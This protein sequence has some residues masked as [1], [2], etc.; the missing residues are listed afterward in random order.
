MQELLDIK[1]LLSPKKPW[2]HL[3]KCSER[4]VDNF[5][6]YLIS[7]AVAVVR[8]LRGKRCTTKSGLFDEFASALQFPY[9]FGE[10]W[11]AFDECLSDLE[12]LKGNAYIFL[13]S[14]ANEILS[15]ESDEELQ[16]FIDILKNIA[17]EWAISRENDKEQPRPAVPFHII[18]QY[19]PEV[20]ETFQLRLKQTKI[21]IDD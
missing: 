9:Y 10:N 15:K 7:Q 19:E 1:N 20:A 17:E 4:E 5:S 11:D 6:N 3:V 8:V 13:I 18:F 2:I 16:R 21:E 12:W 14:Q